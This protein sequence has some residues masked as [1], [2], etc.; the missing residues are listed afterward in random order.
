VY[1][2]MFE[3]QEKAGRGYL[4]EGRTCRF[5][6]VNPPLDFALGQNATRGKGAASKTL[7]N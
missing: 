7:E 2:G 1:E 4:S 5:Y 3:R 6:P